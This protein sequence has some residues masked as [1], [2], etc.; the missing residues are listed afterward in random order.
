MRTTFFKILR[1]VSTKLSRII[2]NVSRICGS[3]IQI[4]WIC[5]SAMQKIHDFEMYL[6][7]PHHLVSLCTFPYLSVPRC[8]C[9]S[10]ARI[11]LYL[12]VPFCTFLY[13]SAN[14]NLHPKIG[15][16]SWPLQSTLRR[17]H[18]KF[19]ASES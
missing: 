15:F 18:R 9:I 4:S 16:W 8:K 1:N 3:A 11:T 17:I 14:G 19:R 2:R 6:C 7:C 10:D 13:L 12:S 5:G